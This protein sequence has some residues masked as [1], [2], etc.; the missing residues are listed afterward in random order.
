M[1]VHQ[2]REQYVRWLHVTRDLSPHTVRAYDADITALE[3]HLG[4]SVESKSISLATHHA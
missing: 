3:R 2:A 4:T 1:Q